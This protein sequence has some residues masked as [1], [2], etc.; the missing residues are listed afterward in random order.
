MRLSCDFWHPPCCQ[1]YK[2]IEIHLGIR[3]RFANRQFEDQT[4]SK[5][6]KNCDKGAVASLKDRQQRVSF[7]GHRVARIFLLLLA[8]PKVLGPLQRVQFSTATLR[9]KR[10]RKEMLIARIDSNQKIFIEAF[11][12]IQHLRI[13]LRNRQRQER[14]SSGDAWRIVRS[15]LNLKEIG[16]SNVLFLTYRGFVFPSTFRNKTGRNRIRC[17]FLSINAHAGQERSEFR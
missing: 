7:S 16:Q 12:T 17:R 1:L 6:K 8:S 11:H 2:K 3:V 14:R 4:I 5:P 9:R 13:G 15:I 10:L